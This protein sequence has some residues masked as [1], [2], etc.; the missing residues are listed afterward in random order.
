[1][2]AGSSS[3]SAPAD[4]L[5]CAGETE[6]PGSTATQPV[7]TPSCLKPLHHEAGPWRKHGGGVGGILPWPW[8]GPDGNFG[9]PSPAALV[10]NPSSECVTSGYFCLH[11]PEGGESFLYFHLKKTRVPRGKGQGKP[12]ARGRRGCGHCFPGHLWPACP[13]SP[14]PRFHG[15]PPAAHGPAFSPVLFGEGLLGVTT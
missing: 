6:C 13:F 2:L 11:S 3:R 1:M 12:A 8:Q 4:I 15:E 7:G 5:F 14:L 10:A 9:S